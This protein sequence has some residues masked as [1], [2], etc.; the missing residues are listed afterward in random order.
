MSTERKSNFELNDKRK[1]KV[2]S[3]CGVTVRKRCLPKCSPVKRR[4]VGP[5]QQ[6]QS[7]GDTWR[8]EKS[9]KKNQPEKK[10]TT[11]SRWE[12]QATPTSTHTRAQTSHTRVGSAGL[13]SPTRPPSKSTPWEQGR[14]TL[15]RRAEATLPLTLHRV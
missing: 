15:R 6:G 12:I 5:V 4:G 13:D 2:S 7:G 1:K 8:K 11:H 14:Q 10:A 3:S 9:R